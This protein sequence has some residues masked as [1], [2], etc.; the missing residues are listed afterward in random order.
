MRPARSFLLLLFILICLSGLSYLF[1]GSK[2]FPS[3][4]YFIPLNIENGTG[5][6]QDISISVPDP[7]SVIVKVNDTSLLSPFLD[8]LKNSGSQV[9]VMYYGD[10]QIEG[11]RITSYLRKSLR[12]GRHGTGPGLFLP[13]MPVMY[14]RSVWL[15]SSP[16]WKRYNYLSYENGE[17]SH[18]RLGSFMTLCRFLPEGTMNNEPVRAF[19]RI[20]PSVYADFAVAEY[21]ILRIF[22]SNSD[23]NTRISVKADRIPVLEQLL[24]QGHDLQEIKCELF[25]AKDVLIEFEGRSSPD[26]YG[27]SIESSEGVIVDNIPRRGSAGLEFTLVDRENLSESL[28][29]L[30]PDLIVLH[31]GLNIVRNIRNDYSYYQRGLMRQIALLKELVPGVQVLVVGVTDM[32]EPGEDGIKSFSNIPQIIRSQREAA[33]QAGAAFWDPYNSMGGE[34]S[35]IRWAE[36]EPALA[37]KDYVHLTYSGADTLSAML[38]NA[39]FSPKEPESQT[40]TRTFSH[41]EVH[42]STVYRNLQSVPGKLKSHMRSLIPEIITY[43]P[44]RPFIFTSPAFWIFFLFVMAGYSLLYRKLFLRHLYLFLV[45]IFFYYKTGGLFLILLV[46]VTIIDFICGILIYKSGEKIY[47]RLFLLV[48]IISNIGIL[49]YFKYTAFII[50]SVNKLAGTDFKV[51]DFLA[52]LSNTYLGTA[53]SISNIILPVGISFFTFQ[54]LSYTVDIYRRKLDPVRNIVDFGFYVSFF[55][56]LIAGPIV[57]ASEFIPQLARE[58]SVSK[59]EFSHALFMILKGLIKKIII[60]DFIAIR[61]I[62]PVFDMPALHSGFENL[63]AIYG[64]GLQIYCDFS[65]YTDIAIGLGLVMGFRL[66][67]NFNSPYKATNLTDFWRRWHISLSRWLRDYLYIPLGGNRKGKFRT[68]INLFITMLLGGLWHGA[69]FRFVLWGGLHGI[70]LI[71]NRIWDTIFKNRIRPGPAGKII[72]GFITFNFISLC[73]IFFRASGMN[74][75]KVMLQQVTENFAP[76]SYSELIQVYGSVFIIIIAGYIVHFLPEKIRESYRGLFIG[77]PLA[78]QATVIM[79]FAV[80]LYSMRTTDI[81]PFIYFRF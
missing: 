13:V 65:G 2:L 43:K 45:S 62:D 31:Y 54:S 30:S 67:L 7:D 79:I 8:S 18:N 42:D 16:N 71:I 57:R 4:D 52:S 74:T 10:S 47:R 21:D 77:M 68:S 70:G 44:D 17:I 75:V 48:S 36:N 73:W 35:I 78:A 72:S 37:Q 55:P 81:L 56:Q 63:M 1:P 33:S 29:K 41:P 32:A 66:P 64:Y 51:Y 27:I 46:L 28:S 80:V 40:L 61:F 25:G 24:N 38:V 15:H 34:S 14:T 39:M 59:R 6:G 11:D 22:Y 12:E 76:V 19:V 5:G 9:R 23:G 49:A 69:S 60:S 26:I 20:R 58:F 50:S 53:F 3:P